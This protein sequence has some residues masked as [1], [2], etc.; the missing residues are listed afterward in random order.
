MSREAALELLRALESIVT[1]SPGPPTLRG[2]ISVAVALPDGPIIWVGRFDR[3][4][5]SS[6]GTEAPESTDA[7]LIFSEEAAKE[8]L[9]TGRVVQHSHSVRA[10]G[11]RTLLYAFQRRYLG[12]KSLLS[13]R[14]SASRSTARLERRRRDR[15]PDRGGSH[16]RSAPSH[17]RSTR[18]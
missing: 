1:Q 3:E 8:V 11:D 10:V 18:R 12:T 5:D 2:V 9:R 15:G 14:V 16:R 7:G 4:V 13:L 17:R 6:I